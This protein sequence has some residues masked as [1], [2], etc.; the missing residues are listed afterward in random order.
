ML[1]G[2]RYELS[3][4]GHARSK[5]PFTVFTLVVQTLC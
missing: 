3:Y 5:E 1:I 4:A 2:K